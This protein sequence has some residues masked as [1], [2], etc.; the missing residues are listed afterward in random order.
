MQDTQ[1]LNGVM[2]VCMIGIIGVMDIM[3][4]KGNGD[5]EDK[6]NVLGNGTGSKFI[7]IMKMEK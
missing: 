3:I 2:K 4:Y 7:T 6:G 5:I 1:V